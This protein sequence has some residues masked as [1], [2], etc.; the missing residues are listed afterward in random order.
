MS[1]DHPLVGASA[2]KGH[3]ERTARENTTRQSGATT[4]YDVL[5]VEGAHDKSVVVTVFRARGSAFSY[6]YEKWLQDDDGLAGK[7]DL[8]LKIFRDGS[9]S[10]DVVTSTVKSEKLEGCLLQVA[11]RLVF[12]QTAAETE[13]MIR[14]EFSSNSH[15]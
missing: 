2:E 8:N 4:A 3:T 5:K 6:C 11:D 12:P 14:F 1:G 15:E 13:A 9:V 7:V 10:G